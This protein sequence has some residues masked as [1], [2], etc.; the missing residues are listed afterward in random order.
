MPQ[1]KITAAAEKAEVTV[2]EVLHDDMVKIA[3]ENKIHLTHFSVSLGAKASGSLM[4]ECSQ[5]ALASHRDLLV[6]ISPSQ[7]RHCMTIMC[8]M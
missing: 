4:Q 6:F 5:H 7:V 8:N 1:K 2:D 3:N